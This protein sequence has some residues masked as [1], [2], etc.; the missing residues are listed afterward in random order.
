MEGDDPIRISLKMHIGHVS[1]K[2]QRGMAE[3]TY[4]TVESGLGF[5]V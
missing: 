4:V 3:Q 5:R 2:P 1:P